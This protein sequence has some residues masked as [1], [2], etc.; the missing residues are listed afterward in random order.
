MQ[1]LSLKLTAKT[2]ALVLMPAV[3]LFFWTY[4][5]EAAVGFSVGTS[6][7][8]LLQAENLMYGN[9][10][11]AS[12]AS[13]SFLLF[14]NNFVDK[15]RI[16]INGNL[17]TPGSI[18]AGAFT[19]PITGGSISAANVSAG[20]FGANVGNG[21]FSFLGNVGIG[22]TSMQAKLDIYATNVA[23]GAGYNAP[24][25]LV[26]H[27]SDNPGANIGGSISLG[28]KWAAGLPNNISSFARLSGRKEDSGGGAGGYLAFEIS[29]NDNPYISERMR[30]T[31]VGNVGISTTTPNTARLV[32][33][34]SATNYTLDAGNYR[35]GNIAAPVMSRDAVNKSYLDSAI[36]AATS[37]IST[38]WGGTTGGN[39]WSL[40]SGNVGIGTTDPANRL[41]IKGDNPTLSIEGATDHIESIIFVDDESTKAS[42]VYDAAD[43]KFSLKS[44]LSPI[45]FSIYNIERM[46]IND[47]G[48]V[49]IGTTTPNARLT[50][51][52]G[53]IFIN[54]AVITSGTPKAAITKEY[55]DASLTAYNS[56]SNL[57]KMNGL[58]MFASSTDWN[59]GIGTT[60]PTDKLTVVGAINS[61][62]TVNGIGLC[63][64][65]DCKTSWN[66]AGWSFDGNTV[67]Q[68][69]S[70]GTLDNYS[71]PF[72]TNGV[73]RMR[74]MNTGNLVLGATST[75]VRL[76]VE[77]PQGAV[78]FFKS[79][80]NGGNYSGYIGNG[81]T[82]SG[83]EFG[84]YYAL[85]DMRL[86]AY[87]VTNSLLLYGGHL[88]T[89][90][91]IVVDTLTGNVGI[92]TTAPTDNLTVVGAINSNSTVNGVGL[93]IA[94]DCKTSW[95]DA[96]AG[97]W[98]LDGNTVAQ[99][100]SFGTLD[101]FA[102]PFLTNGVERM[103]LMETGNLAIGATT[104]GVRL[105]VES[106]QG[107][108]AFFKS[109]LNGGNYSGYIG[110]GQTF[111]GEEFGLYY[112]LNDMRLSTY[113]VTNSLLLYGGH[114]SNDASMVIDTL[115]GNVGLGTSTP[116]AD[117]RLT[118]ASA[119]NYSIDAGNFRIG[120][121][122]TPVNNLDAV[123]KSYL[124]SAVTSAAAGA[125]PRFV[126]VTSN[127]Y[128]GSNGGST[129]YNEANALC[130]ADFT[131]S[132]VCASYELL[133]S[134]NNYSTLPTI[135]AWVFSGPPAYTASANDCEGRT[136]ASNTSRGSY[137]QAPNGTY[138]QGRGL[139]SL[140]D[141]LL[142]F[143]CC[144]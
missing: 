109:T 23:L 135:D 96:G 52:G 133:N 103:R 43:S 111:S 38:L 25:N 28:G 130:A 139:L 121:V 119:G 104:T 45:I 137:W 59:I 89:D 9:V 138:P 39:V 15:L 26:I 18:N 123:N 37:S 108:V 83:E 115:T 58:N 29:R 73:E 22:T 136:T 62:S 51:N 106:P 33:G 131:G 124:D 127:T 92:G 36:L 126:G 85:N 74:L 113:D 80:L 142:R 143:A 140:C 67:T 81:Q 63:I 69:K 44:F 40:N 93:C 90:P 102:V 77:S 110:N 20:Q 84:M 32:I 47:S 35:V 129:G 112:A 10:G 66:D 64:A 14:Q 1:K 41:S 91:A 34:S 5:A 98:K 141:A 87:E 46:L 107:A 76:H 17:T 57:W 49:G 125:V 19:G 27:T 24:G 54:D 8:N 100:Q 134:I 86:A 128:N 144:Q 60:D 7:L 78:A 56:E 75:G 97:G 72:L 120:N 94:G 101:N 3:F 122:A 2:L 99:V 31:S 42:I 132:H 82:F 48:D 50:V 11:A 118:I 6:T 117:T 61:N 21:D 16:D 95:S 30:I 65:G 55:L 12:H 4:R 71:I 70:F 13:S 116:A 88:S 105:H 114:L 53:N 79:T 68:M